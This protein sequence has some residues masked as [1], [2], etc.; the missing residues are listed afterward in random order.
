MESTIERLVR[1]DNEMSQCG[2]G[3]DPL[4]ITLSEVEILANHW[5][6]MG[7]ASYDFAR[8]SL[9]RGDATFLGRKVVVL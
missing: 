2:L 7:R 4:W 3:R 1:I 9:L 8:A 6:Q 5:N